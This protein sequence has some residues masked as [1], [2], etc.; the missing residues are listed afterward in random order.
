MQREVKGLGKRQ[1]NRSLNQ[2][3]KGILMRSIT[4]I[5]VIIII[6]LV[7]LVAYFE[8]PADYVWSNVTIEKVSDGR[9]KSN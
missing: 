8:D 5:Y 4:I 7:F 9:Y 6:I 2:R 3:Q 1:D